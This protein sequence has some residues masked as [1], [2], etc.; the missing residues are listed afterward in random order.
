MKP[1]VSIITPSYNKGA[2]I[3]DTILSV[4][5][6]S[7]DRWELIIVDDC[8]T[9]TSMSLVET[10]FK[11]PRIKVLRNDENKGANFCRNKGIDYARGEYII[12]LDA[13]DILIP[14]C[15]SRRTGKML[16]DESLDFC[17]FTMGVFNSKVGDVEDKLWRP[18]SSDPLKDFLSHRL[19]WSILQPIWKKDFLREIK[20]FDETFKRLQDVELHTRALLHPGVNY[21]MY[22]TQPDCYYRIDEARKNYN[23][24]SFLLRWVEAA[25][26]YCEKFYKLVSPAMGKYLLGTIYQTYI[27]VVISYKKKQ[28]REK[29]FL[30]LENKLLQNPFFM[31]VPSLKKVLVRISK[32]HNLSFYRIPGFN[33]LIMKLFL[34]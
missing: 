17:V 6:Q 2:F 10:T 18:L 33:R 14:E 34:L 4:Q 7:Y 27:Q 19:P 11:D 13:D 8:S 21:K 32:S 5:N 26:Q 22:D 23:Q 1:L 15:L 9:D 25:L 29:D 30:T 16:R 12:F 20:G 28:I 31:R 24:Y 3:T